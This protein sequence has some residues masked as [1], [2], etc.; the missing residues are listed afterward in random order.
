MPGIVTADEQ[1]GRSDDES[2][3]GSES[4]RRVLKAAGGLGVLALAGCLTRQGLSAGNPTD[5]PAGT[6]PTDTPTATDTARGAPTTSDPIPTEPVETATPTDT[7]TEPD[8]TDT[9]T[10]EPTPTEESTETKTP[11]PGERLPRDD[12]AVLLSLETEPVTPSTDT[13]SGAITN[14]YLFPVQNGTVELDAPEGWDLSAT[15]GATFDTLESQYTQDVAWDVDIPDSADGECELTATVT[16]GTTTDS[17]TVE[18][19]HT[20]LVGSP[21]DVVTVLE[22]PFGVDCGGVY[23]T[24]TVEID[25]VEFFPTTAFTENL[26]LDGTDPIPEKGRWWTG[27]ENLSVDPV[28][29]AEVNETNTDITYTDHDALYRT[30]H[31][32]DDDLSYTFSLD[33]GTYEV[34]LHFAEVV[35]ESD[36]RRVFD[37]S[38]N[39]ETV[40]PAFDIHAETGYATALTESFEIETDGDLTIAAHSVNGKPKFGSIEIREA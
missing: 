29:S 38:V 17:V 15:Y 16:Y 26:S 30:E 34:T 18:V 35:F 33:A 11:T 19:T 10:Q 13:I 37:V 22:P 3:C 4:R 21:G 12:P 40:L 7:R 8:P 9:R 1:R 27:V 32:A 31:W 2:R 14:P 20:V 28:P 25:G 24:G 5:T 36:G 6:T 23:T 39:G